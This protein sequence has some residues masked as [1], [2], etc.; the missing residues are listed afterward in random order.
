M[1]AVLVNLV[2]V[3][4]A[5]LVAFGSND[6]TEHHNQAY[7]VVPDHLPEVCKRWIRPDALTGDAHWLILSC[8]ELV[9]R[10]LNNSNRRLLIVTCLYLNGCGC[11]GRLCISLFLWLALIRVLALESRGG[12]LET[13]RAAGDVGRIPLLELRLDQRVN[14]ARIEIGVQSFVTT[15]YVNQ[16]LYVALRSL[17]LSFRGTLYLVFR[18]FTRAASGHGQDRVFLQDDAIV[19][20]RQDV[21]VAV[22]LVEL[23]VK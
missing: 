22:D 2:P 5:L 12:R 9:N 18:V 21:L 4:A 1:L 7:V 17:R 16:V 10:T 13:W 15:S 11:G 8:A 3:H 14:L 23:D 6:G 19:I 20:V